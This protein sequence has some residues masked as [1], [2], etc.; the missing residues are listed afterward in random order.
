MCPY[1]GQKAVF[2]DRLRVP[3]GGVPPLTKDNLPPPPEYK[4]G[5][6]CENKKCT[7]RWEF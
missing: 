3:T 4:P 1:C 6:E 5:W 2:L 7:R